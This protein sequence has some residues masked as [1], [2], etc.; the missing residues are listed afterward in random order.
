M[1]LLKQ[2]MDEHGVDRAVVV[3][4]LYPGEDNSYVADCAARDSE[5]LAAC[6]MWTTAGGRGPASPLLGPG[7]GLP[8]I[9]NPSQRSRRGSDLWPAA[10]YPVWE[11]A[12]DLGI[13]VNLLMR[14]EHVPALAG[15][16]ERF[17]QVP[18]LIDHMAYPDVTAGTSDP[19][20]RDLLELNRFPQIS[21][22]V[23]GYYYHSRQ[24]WPYRD[25]HSFF[26]AFHEAFGTDRLV[27]GSDFPHVLLKCSYASALGLQERFY[28]ELEPA[29]MAAVMGA[30]AAAAY[31]RILS[32]G[33][34]SAGP[35]RDAA[36]FR[37]HSGSRIHG[38][39]F[40][41][42][43]V[44]EWFKEHAWKACVRETVPRVRIPPSPPSNFYKSLEIKN[45]LGVRKNIIILNTRSDTER[46]A[47]HLPEAPTW[48]APHCL[49]LRRPVCIEIQTRR[50][51][52]R[53]Q[54]R[55]AQ[56][57]R[58]LQNPSGSAGP[59]SLRGRNDRSEKVGNRG[60]IFSIL[61][62]IVVLFAEKSR[63]YGPIL[64]L[65]Q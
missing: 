8:G 55:P 65:S 29:E 61:R 49:P 6:A 18:L 23:S 58:S 48:P 63:K 43:E 38:L 17:P 51:S 16:A 41:I 54:D 30:N 10:S 46:S 3:Q 14:M 33:K 26:K 53:R 42:G 39:I 62:C 47:I 27:W 22:K 12:Q 57:S 28:T 32:P 52:A 19:A 21:V 24:G 2:Y 59:R 25:C 60:Q 34:A 50:S 11:A 45:I 44:S 5:R 1:E 64:P 13:A 20:F 37:T 15:L 56:V 36:L 35:R 9:E 31:C 7:T 4:P 40:R